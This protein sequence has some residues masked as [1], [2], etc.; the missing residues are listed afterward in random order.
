MSTFVFWHNS[1]LLTH[2]AS[3]DPR[4]ICGWH[5]LGM[6]Q[7]HRRQPCLGVQRPAL[8]H[9]TH[10][11]QKFNDTPSEGEPISVLLRQQSGTM[12]PYSLENTLKDHISFN[13]QQYPFYWWG[14][15][16]SERLT[17][18][19]DNAVSKWQSL[20]S[21]QSLLVPTLDLSV[22]HHHLWSI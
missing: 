2:S 13:L 4:S 19:R 14:N 16:A 18:V 8:G 11:D 7:K 17:N 21:N 9:A 3:S 22:L 12:V 1:H 6:F 10:N 5:W 20:D 15:W